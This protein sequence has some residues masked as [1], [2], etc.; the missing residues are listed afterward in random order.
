MLFTSWSPLH[1]IGFFL[2]NVWLIHMHACTSF[3]PSYIAAEWCR[4]CVTLF[5]SRSTYCTGI[6]FL[7]L[8][9]FLHCASTCGAFLIIK[10]LRVI[11]LDIS[12]DW[13][14]QTSSIIT[15]AIPI[16]T[17]EFVDPVPLQYT[18]FSINVP[19]SSINKVN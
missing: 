18:K 14:M 10:F 17:F 12:A 5:L 8:S 19:A 1:G 4:V 3:T 15:L 2:S 7:Y 13:P 9:I 6:L 11:M 16:E